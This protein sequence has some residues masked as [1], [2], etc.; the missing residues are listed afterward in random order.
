[1][2]HADATFEDRD[3][4]VDDAHYQRCRFARC[5]LIYRGGGV[6]RID[7]CDMVDCSWHF[8]DAAERTLNMLRAIYHGLGG[9]GQQIVEGAFDSIRA[10]RPPQAPSTF[11][12]NPI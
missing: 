4:V 8:E 11:A 3:V 6:P 10:P 9:A 2:T 12:T 5:R 7:D 1:M